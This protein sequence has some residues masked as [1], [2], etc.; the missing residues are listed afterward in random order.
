MTKILV[1]NGPNLNLLGKR[2]PDIYGIETLKKIEHD[3]D[4]YAKIIGVEVDF[5]QSN[6]EGELVNFIQNAMGKYD[7]II[8]NAGAYTHYSIAIHDAILATGLPVIEV[9]LSNIYK[10]EEFRHKSIIASACVGQI[11]GFGEKSYKLALQY[12]RKDGE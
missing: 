6:I 11:T 9:H 10:R 5:A 8:L 4:K 7:G 2:E 3:L 1:I 12:F